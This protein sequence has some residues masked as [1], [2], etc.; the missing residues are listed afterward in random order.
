MLTFTEEMLLLLG[1][2]QGTFL[3]V[4]QYA[5]ECALAGA[6]LLDL[7]FA[8]RIDT[9]LESLVV[10]DPNPT[11]ISF[12][13]RVLAKVV[14][15]KDTAD[16]QAWIRSLSEDDVEA[17]REAALTALVTKGVLAKREDRFL[18]LLRSVRYPTID[19]GVVERIKKRL[20]D[21]LSD[22]IPDARDVALLSLVDACDI[23]PDLFP[24]R[25]LQEERHRIAQLRRM[26]LIGREVAGTIAEIQRTIIQAARA[27]AARFGKLRLV[28]SGV[29]VG[30]VVATL[31]APRVPI[32]DSFGPSIL[33]NLWFD[34]TWQ[35]W[36][37]YVLLGLSLLGLSIAVTVKKRLVVRVARSHPWRLTHFVLGVSCLVALFAHTGFRFGANLNALL[38]GCYLVVV[39]SGA[40]S[41][42]ALR[43]ASG[44]QLVGLGTPGK[45]RRA[46][47]RL[48]VVALCPLPALLVVHILTAYSF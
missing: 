37:G 30:A 5:L 39:F 11:G 40:L 7:A 10:T 24:D 44:V 41:E 38:M 47:I 23:L 12:L 2:E 42:V 25:E 1:D 17:I 29:A 33:R 15:R 6:V 20:A 26:D 32:P 43:V 3:P 14:A 34:G 4:R 18:R 36:S 27:E 48:H 9:D 21:V 35:E 22:E 45:R 28:L 8:Y 46:L 31:V 16:T 13:D 19:H